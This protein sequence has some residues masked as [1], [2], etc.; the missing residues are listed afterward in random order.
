MDITEEAFKKAQE[1]L[2]QCTDP[3]GLKASALESG[4][5]QVW[6]RDSMITLLGAVLVD[7]K[8]AETAIRN[9][10]KTLMMGQA[11]NGCIPAN[12]IISNK[13]ADFRAYIDGNCWYVIGHRIFY[14][15]YKDKKFLEDSWES[16][17][18]TLTWLSCQDVYNQ[19]LIVMQEGADWMDNFSIR[20]RGLCINVLYY[21]ALVSASKLAGDLNEKDLCDK[22]LEKSAQVRH[23]INQ[24]FWVDNKKITLSDEYFADEELNIISAYKM[25][26]LHTMRYYLPFITFKNF[27]TWFDTLGNLLAIMFNI[28]NEE[29]SKKI[30]DYINMVGV[31][32][33][34]A[35]AIYP[36][37]YPGES[38]WREY[39]KSHNLNLP[40]QY[41]NGGVWPFIGGFYI[42]ALIKAGR[43][44]EAEKELIKLAKVNQKGREGEWEFNEWMHGKTGEPMGMQFQAWSAGMYIYAYECLKQ[45]KLLFF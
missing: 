27:G 33:F 39:F 35:K 40:H 37:V 3:L 42:A 5:P 17:Q 31:N 45:K 15:E 24:L 21:Q 8:D 7:D 41:H 11:D 19:D 43:F 26:I 30:L 2:K 6:A 16:I 34:P 1:I 9:S 38:E 25:T 32:E 36:P 28:A 10:L 13:K 44:T 23:K 18:K 20:G 12:V 14:E 22:Y 4:Y 29:Q